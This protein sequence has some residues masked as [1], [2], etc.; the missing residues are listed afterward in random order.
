MSV[1]ML[2]SGSPSSAQPLKV[3]EKSA[4]DRFGVTA[5]VVGRTGVA[6][7]NDPN[8]MI[9]N[10]GALPSLRLVG[11][12]LFTSNLE[13]GSHFYSTAVTGL[14]VKNF[15]TFSAAY[16]R[17]DSG[18]ITG[19]RTELDAPFQY[20]ATDQAFALGYGRVLWP[21]LGLMGGFT[22]RF[23]Q[24][25]IEKLSGN[26]YGVDGGLFKQFTVFQNQKINVGA[27]YQELVPLRMSLAEETVNRPVVRAGLGYEW[28]NRVGFL[29][30]RTSVGWDVARYPAGETHHFFG[31]E[32]GLGMFA[33]RGGY[34]EGRPSFGLGTEFARSRHTFRLDYGLVNRAYAQ[35]HTV[36]LSWLLGLSEPAAHQRALRQANH[37]QLKA[38]S[39]WMDSAEESSGD[40]PAPGRRKRA[41]S[42][43]W[44]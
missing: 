36:S 3:V 4:V 1:A 34:Q 25:Q 31:V 29:T 18:D 5:L 32:Y 26:G 10:P 37:E 28:P 13:L 15:G 42:D 20:K 40:D 6:N 38:E 39:D 2:L 11:V 9:Y 19:R 33:L 22:L 44:R 23:R 16:M 27:T 30:G 24:K 7:S 43:S 21:Q 41:G 14:S 17:L 8:S 35:L 12:H